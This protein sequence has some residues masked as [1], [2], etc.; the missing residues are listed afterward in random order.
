MMPG[1]LGGC[2]SDK[3]LVYGVEKLSVIDASIIPL[4]S[5]THLQATMYVVAEKG[6]DIIRERAQK[7]SG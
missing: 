2:V 6:A 5:A 3:L 4:T 1:D 7:E